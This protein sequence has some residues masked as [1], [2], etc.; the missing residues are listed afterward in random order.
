MNKLNFELTKS[1][2]ERATEKAKDL[3][4]F[5][6]SKQGTTACMECVFHKIGKGCAI[7]YPDSHWEE[8]NDKR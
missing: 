3:Q 6:Q 1:A 4:K 8:I 2:D 5:C 7:G